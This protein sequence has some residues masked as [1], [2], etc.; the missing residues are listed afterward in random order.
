M[1]LKFKNENENAASE[2]DTICPSVISPATTNELNTNL[3][4]GTFFNT[5]TKFDMVGFLGIKFKSVVNTSLDGIKAIL[6]A[7]KSG[8]RTI[9][10]S[11]H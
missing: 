4:K 3:N 5:S 1:P 6:K 7:Y 8:K 9:N 2:Q 10:Y 11:F